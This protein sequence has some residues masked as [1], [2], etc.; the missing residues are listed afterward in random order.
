MSLKPGVNASGSQGSGASIGK[1]IGPS[2]ARAQMP[3]VIEKILS[4]YVDS[5]H[6]DEKFLDTVR[7]IGIT[8][9][10]ERVYAK[11]H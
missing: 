10:K 11:H 5:R 1:V 7:R 4:V 3:D 2:F 8:P 6:D 9:F